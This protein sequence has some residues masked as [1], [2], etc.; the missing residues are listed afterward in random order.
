[1]PES[2]LAA[3]FESEAPRSQAVST[4]PG[5]KTN[6]AKRFHGSTIRVRLMGFLSREVGRQRRLHALC[7]VLG[8][9]SPEGAETTRVIPST[10]LRRSHAGRARTDNAIPTAAELV[11]VED[12]RLAIS[13]KWAGVLRSVGPMVVL[14]RVPSCKPRRKPRAGDRSSAQLK[15][16]VFSMGGGGPQR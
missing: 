5:A 14:N 7:H 13:R 8:R 11:C 1:M 2:G 6:R 15:A 4:S 12:P 3:V 9:T 10:I 16:F